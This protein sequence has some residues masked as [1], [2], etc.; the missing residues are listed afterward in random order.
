MNKR[1]IP[2]IYLY[3]GNAVTGFS[4]K[5]V[6]SDDPVSLAKSFA[7]DG[8]DELILFD[9][10]N[11]DNEHEEAL[12][13]IRKITENLQIP[14]IGAGNVKRME[15]VKK[16]LYA[17]CSKACLNY[18]KQSNVELTAEVSKKFG[19]DKIVA[20]FAIPAVIE[21]NQ[22]LLDAYVGE[23]LCVD[24]NGITGCIS[25]INMPFIAM[26]PDIS[27]EKTMEYL[28]FYSISGISG[29]FV[30]KNVSEIYSL[31]SLCVQNN[32]EV[33]SYENCLPFEKLKTLDNGLVPVVAQ[34][35]KTGEVLMVAYMNKE[36]YENTLKTG[37]M[38]YYSRSR[39]ELWVKGETSGHY[40]YLKAL[41]ADCDFDTLLAKVYQ[42]GAACH[43][44][45][46]SCFFNEI[47][48]KEYDDENPLTVF[49]KV[50]D[51]IKDRKIHPKDGSYTNYLFDK[52]IDKILKKCGEEATEIII[53]AKN[54]NPEE[55]KYEIADFLYHCMVLMVEKGV[56]WDEITKELANR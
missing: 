15:D 28:G 11:D 24:E 38:T 48:Q 43:T 16:L 31:K 27:L 6:I 41:H 23:L 39:K 22:E 9:L 25:S 12:N 30:N 53:A 19:K 40:Q 14:V 34:D 2:C 7:D 46:Y 33:Y 17:G 26:L 56:S 29:T 55:I 51:V 20:A 45:N 49:N 3:K 50:F 21:L 52:G 36:A 5:N 35:Y 13:T 4:D 8:A 47:L 44:G 37:K 32:I 42:V 54:P 1:F 18:D 10:S